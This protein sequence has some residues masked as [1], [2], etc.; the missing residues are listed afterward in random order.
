MRRC[1]LTCFSQMI[2]TI[3]YSHIYY[4]SEWFQTVLIHKHRCALMP[5]EKVIWKES[6]WHFSSF[7]SPREK[8][9]TTEDG[10]SLYFLYNVL[11]PPTLLLC[12]GESLLFC[13]IF[14]TLQSCLFIHLTNAIPHLPKG[15][16]N[17]AHEVS[18]SVCLSTA[19][20]SWV[21]FWVFSI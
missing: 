3:P 8:K 5:L 18:P 19:V 21:L 11:S 6:I 15:S 7:V 1:F 14:H 16:G 9:T 12:P 10:F 4:R 13:W 20:I 17:K 2:F